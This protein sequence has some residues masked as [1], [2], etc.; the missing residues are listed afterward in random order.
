MD[1]GGSCK[2]V[3]QVDRHAGVETIKSSSTH[4]LQKN[5]ILAGLLS[6]TP[7]LL[8]T[9]REG[10]INLG[11]NLLWILKACFFFLIYLQSMAR[12]PFVLVLEAEYSLETVDSALQRDHLV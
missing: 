8:G 6:F 2:L 10:I 4:S 5:S 12:E 9:L 7:K 3:S 1:D 11:R